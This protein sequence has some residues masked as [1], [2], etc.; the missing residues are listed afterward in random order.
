VGNFIIRIKTEEMLLYSREKRLLASLYVFICI[1]VSVAPISR[2]SVKGYL[3]DFH[4]NLLGIPIFVKIGP[5]MLS[6]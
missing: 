6:I 2:I 1:F 5:K 3:G 4:G